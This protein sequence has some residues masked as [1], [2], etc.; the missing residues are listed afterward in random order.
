MAAEEA[1][2][3]EG[4]CVRDELVGGRELEDQAGSIC[5]SG[6]GESDRNARLASLLKVAQTGQNIGVCIQP[7]RGMLTRKCAIYWGH[8]RMGK[9]FAEC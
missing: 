7:H 8:V 9:I 5:E 6:R 3:S 1:G 4:E 2:A